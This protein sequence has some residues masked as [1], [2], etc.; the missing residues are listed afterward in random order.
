M[1]IIQRV[2]NQQFKKASL[3]KD[4]II[5]QELE[6]SLLL[7]EKRY[8]HQIIAK[9][10]QRVSDSILYTKSLEQ[11]LCVLREKIKLLKKS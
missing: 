3:R 11:Q 10:E 9:L 7:R 5:E 6:I 1:S 8:A 2:Y 4:I